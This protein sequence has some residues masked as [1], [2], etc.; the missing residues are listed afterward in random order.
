MGPGTGVPLT[1]GENLYVQF[2]AFFENTVPE[3]KD[4]EVTSP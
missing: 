3:Y 4:E 2:A 1:H